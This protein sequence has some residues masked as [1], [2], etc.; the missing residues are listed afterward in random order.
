MCPREQVWL[1]CRGGFVVVLGGGGLLACLVVFLVCFLFFTF[2][3]TEEAMGLH[4]V[5][6]RKRRVMTKM[7][8]IF[9]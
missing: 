5:K 9:H 4:V 7:C 8:N 6:R 1:Q 3:K 2:L